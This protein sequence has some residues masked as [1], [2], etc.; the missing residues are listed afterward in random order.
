MIGIFKKRQKQEFEQKGFFKKLKEGLSKTRSGLQGRID[1]LIS[2]K[3]VIDEEIL[4]EIEEVLF[5]ADLGVKTAQE[6]IDMLRGGVSQKELKNPE[7]LKEA[8]KK[9]MIEFLNVPEVKHPVPTES[10]PFVIMVIGINGVGKTTTI[11]KV[12]HM[13]KEQGL[14]VMFVA[15]DTFRAA[16]I[17]QL[18]IWGERVG[19]EVISQREGAD[20]SAVVF[21]AIT[22][23]LTRGFDVV[24]IDTAGRLHTKRNLMEELKKIQRVA[25]KRLPGAPHEVWLVLDATTGQ[26]AIIQA[27]MFQKEIGITDI[28]LTKLDGTSKGGVVVGI[29]NQL[30]VP[31]RYIGIGEGMDDLREFDPEQFVNAI[32]EENKDN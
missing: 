2:G 16:A 9:K 26:N 13:M 18:Q 11:A 23:A 8:L 28:I 7:A 14:K 30:K 3:K 32:F 4:D 24:L 21:D 29:T 17:E 27:E 10:E 20:P 22:S 25:G 31:V 19:A 12:G 15:G 1:R 6:L 5:T